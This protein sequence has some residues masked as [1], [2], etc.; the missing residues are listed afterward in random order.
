MV[1]VPAFG[2]GVAPGLRT[3]ADDGGGP[4]PG[5]SNDPV[6]LSRSE[7]LDVLAALESSAFVLA[8][9]GRREDILVIFEAEEA[10]A[11]MVAKLWPDEEA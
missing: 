3:S 11:L 1:G 8:E 9:V 5:W 2:W 6:A 7:A 4:L 10:A